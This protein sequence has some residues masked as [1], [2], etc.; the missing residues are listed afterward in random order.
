MWAPEWEFSTYMVVWDTFHHRLFTIRE[1]ASVAAK[2]KDQLRVALSR[3]VRRGW[4][5][6]L[7]RGKYLAKPSNRI[8]TS[9]R[10]YSTTQNAL[11]K[12]GI[13]HPTYIYGSVADNL[14]SEGSDVDLLMVTGERWEDTERKLPGFHLTFI[15]PRYVQK[16]DFFIYTVLKRGLP[17]FSRLEVPQIGFDPQSLLK[18]AIK[19]HETAKFDGATYEPQLVDATGMTAKYILYRSGMLPPTSNIGA[20]LELAKVQESY[21]EAYKAFEVQEV[22]KA[23]EMVMGW[24]KRTQ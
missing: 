2:D 5:L 22:E 4:L 13:S 23:L 15:D 1:L 14:A 19:I 9:L 7:G 21:L 16:P 6:R 24:A 17:L 20:I 10:L 3:L 11:K 12:A 8:V 18:E